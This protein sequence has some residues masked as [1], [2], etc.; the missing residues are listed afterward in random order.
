MRRI[1]RPSARRNYLPFIACGCLGI[2][3]GVML[4][5]GIVVLLVIPALPGMALQISGFKTKGNTETVFQNIAPMPT[6]AVQNGVQP[7]QAIINLG[8]LGSQTIDIDPNQTQY[9]VV[10][11]TSNTGAPL[12]T[13][14]FTESGLMDM[15]YQRADL[16]GN[17]N[18]Q[19][20]NPRI[21]LRPGGAIIYADVYVPDFG[22]WQAAGIVLRLDSSQRQLQVAGVDVGGVLYDVPPNGV[23]QQVSDVARVGNE[24]LNQLS[25][26]ASGGR[27]ALSQVMIDDTTLTLVMR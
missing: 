25:L 26:E 14:S 17:S 6:I 12:A 10:V 3:V 15:C 16:C 23:G 19:Y 11:G 13:V 1:Q 18:A 8:S 20:R 27:Y 21:D 4:V 2:G 22:V 24:L 9:Q 5:A 7:Q